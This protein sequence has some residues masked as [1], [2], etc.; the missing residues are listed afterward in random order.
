MK[1]FSFIAATVLPISVL[2]TPL[3]AVR[4]ASPETLADKGRTAVKSHATIRDAES[5]AAGLLKRD[6]TC[7]IVHVVTT[8]DCWWLP[9]HKH[10]SDGNLL[11]KSIP[12]TTNNIVFDCFARCENVQGITYG[13]SLDHCHQDF[14]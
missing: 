7:D 4:E 9:I 11:I 14:A 6:A 5:E 12:G 13:S 2:S 10:Q 3:K 1:L 8:V